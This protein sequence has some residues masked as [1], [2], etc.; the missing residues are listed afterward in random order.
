MHVHG[1]GRG[2]QQM[3]VQRR[4]PDAALVEGDLQVAPPETDAVNS[5]GQLRA[6]SAKRLCNGSPVVV[7][8]GRGGGQSEREHDT[9]EYWI[10]ALHGISPREWSCFRTSTTEMRSS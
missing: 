5:A 6:G 3:V 1:C 8:C 2:A 4:D 10:K 9:C 7:G